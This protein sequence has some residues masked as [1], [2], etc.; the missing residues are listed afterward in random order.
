VDPDAPRILRPLD[1]GADGLRVARAVALIAGVREGREPAH[2]ER[3]AVL[4]ERIAAAME[5][6]APIVHRC[7]VAGWL[8]DIGMVALPDAALAGAG[9]AGPDHRAHVTIGAELVRRVDELA[10]AAPAIRHHHERWDG[11][12]YPDGLAGDAIPVEA[13]VVAAADAVA[14][15]AP[16]AALDPRARKQAAAR[17]LREAGARLDPR[18]VEAARRVLAAEAAASGQYLRIA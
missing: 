3:V 2:A 4:A 1:G 12:G 16:V 11:S 18:T 13:R 17:L 14:A 5:L 8:H 6:A 9:T 7:A 10:D 15:V